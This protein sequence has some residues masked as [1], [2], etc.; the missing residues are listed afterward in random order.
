MNITFGIITDGNS[1]NYIIEII[2]SIEIQNI[3]NYEIL[4][5][6]NT[7][8]NNKKN[9]RII[10]FDETIKRGWIT[11][12]KNIINKEAKYNI[13]VFMHDY[14]KFLPN[15]YNGMLKFGEDWDIC[16]NIIKNKSGERWFDWITGRASDEFKV[17]N[18]SA[19]YDYTNTH[20][21]YISGTYFICKKYVLEKYPFDENRSWGELEDVE[22]STKWNHYLKYKMNIYSSVQLLKPK[23]NPYIFAE[24]AKK[25]SNNSQ[26]V[27][28]L[29]EYQINN[30][31][32]QC[33]L[34]RDNKTIKKNIW[35]KNQLNNSNELFYLNNPINKNLCIVTLILN[36]NI[37][38]YKKNL[39]KFAKNINHYYFFN[40]NNLIN[41]INN[42]KENI[43]LFTNTNNLVIENI[44]YCYINKYIS[45][46]ENTNNSYIKLMKTEEKLSKTANIDKKY[47]L[48]HNLY[49]C[50]NILIN[51]PTLYKKDILINILNN[52]E[53]SIIGL[54][55]YHGGNK[56]NENI[57][58]SGDYPIQI[59]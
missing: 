8:I 49:E 44:N 3:E 45:I 2:K 31:Y 20:K 17:W 9:L 47:T 32:L 52:K 37:D 7:R 30:P 53:D 56:L 5:V 1:D 40:D 16:M 18:V 27:N 46:L 10:N 6:G 48:Y 14:I 41:N 15:W 29:V 42:I 51:I 59:N 33:G 55:S 19:P 57:W 28:Y 34:E 12:K 11:K 21:M 35:W 26:T 13:I 54:Y 24:N 38:N 4:I 36:N 58:K 22:W 50:N 23:S 43:I 39:N 25:L